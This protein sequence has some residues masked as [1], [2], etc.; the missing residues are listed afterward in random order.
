[1]LCRQS[2]V[3]VSP[4]TPKLFGIRSEAALVLLPSLLSFPHKREPIEL[5]LQLPL[6]ALAIF[7][8]SVCHILIIIFF[9]RIWLDCRDQGF[10][11]GGR[12]TLPERAVAGVISTGRAEWGQVSDL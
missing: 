8:S 12:L 4:M 7:A 6:L 1:M 3:S 2:E 10:G 11:G 9:L 5:C